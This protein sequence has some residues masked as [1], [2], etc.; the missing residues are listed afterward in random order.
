[1]KRLMTVSVCSTLLAAGLAWGQETSLKSMPLSVVKTVPKSDDT[2]VDATVTKQI[3]D[4]LVGRAIADAQRMQACPP[5]SGKPLWDNN[6]R[7]TVAGE[8]VKDV[9]V[10]GIRSTFNANGI[11]TTTADIEQ[12]SNFINQVASRATQFKGKRIDLINVLSQMRQAK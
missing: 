12:L 7:F 10:A 2:N 11:P 3:V 9:S 6:I 1:M 5:F 4:P 8:P